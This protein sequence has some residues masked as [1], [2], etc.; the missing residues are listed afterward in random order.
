MSQDQGL[1]TDVDCVFDGVAIGKSETTF[2][3]GQV[4]LP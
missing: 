2:S 3:D 4:S 1:A